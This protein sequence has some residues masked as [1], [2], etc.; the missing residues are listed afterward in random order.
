[1]AEAK[2]QGVTI[3]FPQDFVIGTAFA[4]DAKVAH[5]ESI[6]QGIPDGWMVK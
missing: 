5:V 3:H 1:M 6:E 2:E 4:K